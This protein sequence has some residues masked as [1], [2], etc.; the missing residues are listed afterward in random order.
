MFFLLAI[1]AIALV[2]FY[3]IIFQFDIPGLWK[4]ALVVAEMVAVNRIL[5]TRYKLPSELGLVL[6]KNKEGI[7]AFFEKREPNFKGK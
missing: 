1:I 4:F 2:L 5:I 3:L 6:V 7:E